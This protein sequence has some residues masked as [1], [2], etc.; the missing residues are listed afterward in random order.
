MLKSFLKFTKA[1]HTIFSIP[2]L[3][4]SAYLSNQNI[5]P[6]PI[7]LVFLILAATGARIL[8]MAMNRI[9][10][11]HIDKEN[12]RTKDRE[13]PSGKLSL[14]KA[15]LIAGSGLVLYLYA[16]LSL[17]KLA[18]YLSPLPIFILISY[19]YLKRITW[20]C[21]F[22]IGVVIALAP[23]GSFVAVTNTV[24]PPTSVILLTVFSF[25]WI[26]GFDIIYGLQDIEFDQKQGIYSIPAKFGY[27]KA[28][29]IARTVHLTAFS[30]LFCLTFLTR[31]NPLQTSLLI[32]TGITLILANSEIMAVEKRFFPLS[33]IAGVCGAIIPVL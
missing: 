9:I 22:G 24:T 27:T 5:W 6:K 7:I 13:I 8:G 1:E 23:L 15:Y 28:V 30:A 29:W 3:F 32:I 26:S 2:L 12:P 19:S 18:L 11:R 31:I 33:A 17:G 4:S 16:C 10:D 21:H 14:K 25:F 20:L